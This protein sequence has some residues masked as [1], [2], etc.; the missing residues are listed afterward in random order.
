[1][2]PAVPPGFRIRDARLAD[3]PRVA[4]VGRAADLAD[5]GELDA[6]EDWL[7]DDWTRPRF[8]P[9]S[10][11]W[12][13]EQDA[14]PI[15]A[16]VYTW[17]EDPHV[18]FDSAGY[19]HP[20]FRGRGI[21][22]VLVDVVERRALRDRALVPPGSSIEVLHSF[23]SDASGLRDPDAS[24]ARALLEAS[25]YGSE[26]EYLH[27]G[28]DVPRGFV[29]GAPPAGITIRP[30]SEADD[31]GIVAVMADAFD[32]PWD[33]DE[34]REEFR[35]SHTY[36]PSLW[37]VAHDGDHPVGALFSYVTNGRGQVSALGVR[38]PWRR[39]GIGG[40]LLRAAFVRLRDR[41][42]PDVRLN[43]DSD[44][45][46]RA[47]RLYDRAGMRLRRRW[48]IVSKTLLRSGG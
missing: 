30:R 34:A 1:M 25:G 15:V 18:R 4:A 33:Y 5:I 36:D 39:R 29:A 35:N 27:L 43:V 19:V 7:H 14:G 10:D 17:D 20:D 26:R 45:A 16:F 24:G 6:D 13:V 9:S 22:S 8:D 38:A 46:S 32:D 11:A 2:A 12:I 3:I 40:A 41:G 47:S 37:M 23:D 28:I 48:L 21:G 44:N 42:V 31:R